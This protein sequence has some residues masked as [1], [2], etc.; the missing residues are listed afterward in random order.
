VAAQE[1]LGGSVSTVEY[2]EVQALVER[3]L[4]GCSPS[5][6]RLLVETGRLAVVRPDELIFRQGERITLTAM[7]RGHGAFRRTTVDGQVLMV[8][9]ARP[10]D[11]FGYSS[12]AGTQTPVDLVALTQGD[13]V[14][15]KGAD[16]RRI[17]ASDAA[18]ALSVIDRMAQFLGSL[19]ERLDGFLHQD[20]RRRV[21]RVLS[22]HRQL[23]FADPVILSRSHLPGLVGTSREMT[24]RVLRE[25]ER[26]GTLARVGRTGLRLLR[27]DLLDGDVVHPWRE[28][29]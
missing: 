14:L 8:D 3:A 27:P 10:G 5:T 28:A 1:S 29:T 9:V 25:L 23:F 4:P 7:V 21:I 6:Y 26:E 19:T 22:R 13:V 15:W 24:G 20:A 2:A 16:I 12:I 18:L 11:L 17:A